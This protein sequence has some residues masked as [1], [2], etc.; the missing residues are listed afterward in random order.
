MP[1]GA[2]LIVAYLQSWGFSPALKFLTR[3]IEGVV[4]D[5]KNAAYPT[6]YGQVCTHTLGPLA[7]CPGTRRLLLRSLTHPPTQHSGVSARCRIGGDAGQRRLPRSRG[8]ECGAGSQHGSRVCTQA[9]QQAAAAHARGSRSSSRCEG[10]TVLADCSKPAVM[11]SCV[12]LACTVLTQHLLHPTHA[13]HTTQACLPRLTRQP[14]E[15]SLPLSLSSRAAAWGWTACPP[16]PC[17]PPPRCLRA[18]WVSCAARARRW[19]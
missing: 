13:A 12:A 9:P 2:G 7:A 19:G 5:S 6:S 4:D 14:P 8:A 1:I 15:P 18:S 10:R 3:A 16:A 11:R 17:L